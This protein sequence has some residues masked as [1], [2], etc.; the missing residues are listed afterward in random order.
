MPGIPSQPWYPFPFFEALR[1]DE[2]MNPLTLVVTGLYGKPLPAQN[3][4]PIRMILPWKYGY[5][6]PKS[7]VKIE[8]TDKQPP[9]FWNKLQPKE[10]GFYSNV[11]PKRPHPRWSQA[12]EKF[13]PTMELRPTLAYNGY[14]NY[15]ADLYK[16]DEF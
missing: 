13:L 5:K 16:G 4:A 14:E 15:V 11:N 1:L 12:Q 7:I 6:S 8:F 3:G 10:Y 9:T 2:A